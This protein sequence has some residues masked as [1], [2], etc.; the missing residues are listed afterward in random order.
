MRRVGSAGRRRVLAS[1]VAAAL[2]ACDRPPPEAETASAAERAAP[3]LLVDVTADSGV[4]FV[5][6]NGASPERLLPETMGSGLAIFDADGD[7]LADLLFA[8]GAP[9]DSEHA[10]R[11]LALYR[12]LGGLRFEHVEGGGGLRVA[13]YAMGLAVGDV[14]GDSDLD[15]LVTTVAPANGV[16]DRLFINRGDGTFEDASSVWGLAPDGGFG[17]SAAFFDADG[18]GDLDLFSGRYVEWSL[19]TDVGCSPDGEHRVYCTPEV[20]DGAISRFYRNR[21]GRFV[22]E[23]RAVGITAAGKTLGVT[24]VDVEGDGRLDLAIA[25]DTVPNQLWI[26]LGEAGFEERAP[27]AGFAVGSSGSARG[28][29]GI[30]AGDLDA[31][32]HG[33]LVVGNFANETAGLFLGEAEGLFRDATAETRL[34]IPTLLSL[35]FGTLATDLDGDGR[36]D[37]VFANGHIEPEIARVSDHRQSYEQKL[38]VFLNRGDHFVE[39]PG[40]PARYVGR[41]LAAGDLDGDGD[42]DLVLS[43]NGGPAVVL[44]NDA[45]ASRHLRVRLC[46]PGG[47]TWGYGAATAFETTGG[48][49]LSRR[50]EA[51]GSYLSSSEPILAL[52]LEAGERLSRVVVDWPG[53][54][55]DE[56]GAAELAEDEPLLVLAARTAAPTCPSAAPNEG[57]PSS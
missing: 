41:G 48:R 11:P 50:L 31:D 49:T 16:G 23:T 46:G 53:G 14:D 17:S 26:N 20:Y 27:L 18:D 51:A 4:D 21:D 36:L 34:G 3:A 55:R 6:T 9:L 54:A 47:N 8:D 39:T 2:L 33:D 29:M 38:Q 28:G 30:A 15:V 22:D 57:A 56:Y 43:Q 45:P 35:T 24:V 13:G 32:G 7:G 44:R 10:T 5:H 12:N 37:V 1:L 19:A 40:P 25:N 52:P 42:P